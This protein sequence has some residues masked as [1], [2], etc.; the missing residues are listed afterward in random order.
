MKKFWIKE[1]ISLDDWRAIHTLI[2]TNLPL[3]ECLALL[4]NKG[5]KKLFERILQ[6]LKAGQRIDEAVLPYLDKRLKSA[7]SSFIQVLTF[8]KALEMSLEIY[9]YDQKRQKQLRKDLVYPG[10][11]FIFS[12]FFRPKD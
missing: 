9:D 6:A 4:I 3:Q 1:V 12:L 2:K 10:L 7:F 5:N 8:E 11:L